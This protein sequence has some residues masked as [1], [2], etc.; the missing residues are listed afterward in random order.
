VNQHISKPKSYA[1]VLKGNHPVEISTS[2]AGKAEYLRKSISRE[3][4][5][6]DQDSDT[7]SQLNLA[8]D[9]LE[10][11]EEDTKY[12]VDNITCRGRREF[13]DIYVELIDE[14]V[15]QTL[16]QETGSEKLTIRMNDHE[17]STSK[18]VEEKDSVEDNEVESFHVVGRQRVSKSES[19]DRSAGPSVQHSATQRPKSHSPT[20]KMPTTVNFFSGNPSV[21]LTKGILHIYKDKQMTSLDKEVAR[22]EMLCMMG[23]PAS[24]TIHDLIEFIAPMGDCVTYM[25]VLRDAFPNQYMLLIKFRDQAS[26]DE[27]YSYFNNRQF[28][29]IE[30][31]ICYLVYVAKI[32]IMTETEGGSLP[33]MNLTE[34]P[35]CPVCLE[36]MEE[37]D[38]GILTVLCNHAF[39]THCLAQWGDTSCPVCRYCQ[40][41]EEVADQRCMQ[42]GSQESL[43]ICLICGH[44]GCGRYVGTH[45]KKHFQDTNHTYAMQLGTNRVW[46]YAGDN[47]VH[48]LAQNKSDGKLVELDEGGNE[49][50][51]EK[52]DS[53][54]L[55]YS[56]LLSTQLE[57]QRIYFTEQIQLAVKDVE[58]K[59][60][61]STE[62]LE[63]ERVAREKAES[64]LSETVKEKHALEKKYNQLHTK[65][66]KVLTDLKDERQMNSSLQE[67]QKSW[68]E[69]V[70]NL[71]KQLETKDREVA[72]LREQLRDIMFYLDA[73]QKLAT[74][75]GLSQEELQGGQVIVGEAGTPLSSQNKKTRKKR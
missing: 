27:F 44:V 40:T 63:Q 53:L 31:H 38:D 36:K 16:L 6:S 4:T 10:R 34:L 15:F 35:N 7:L 24:Y 42:C 5:L 25:Q 65:T 14:E 73:Q 71:E 61:E 30:S 1:S 20:S 21:E 62:R 39:H 9:S 23:V 67:N 69:R 49:F 2:A 58:A 57:S 54:S 48:R 50:H 46:D 45:A 47:Y 29:S 28:N 55:E 17:A 22:S 26:T 8:S 66:S 75:S 41:P 11:A 56:Y 64:K 32:E 18:V 70:T 12:G 59:F 72:E 13:K 74:S 60:K 52:L 43:W 19:H 68:Q 3:R 33:L 51:E 37:S